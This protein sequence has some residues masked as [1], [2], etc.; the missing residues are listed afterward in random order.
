MSGKEDNKEQETMDKTQVDEEDEEIKKMR[1]DFEMIQKYVAQLEKRKLSS[2]GKVSDCIDEIMNSLKIQVGGDRN[3]KGGEQVERETDN[4]EKN[5]T[6]KSDEMSEE[7]TNSTQERIKKKKKLKKKPVVSTN[8]PTTLEMLFSKLDNRKVP[9]LEAYIEDNGLDLE[10]YLERFEDYF[11]E[12]YKGSSYLWLGELEGKLKGR[13]LEGYKSVKLSDDSFPAV[14]KKLIKWYRDE[15]ESRKKISRKNFEK[16]KMKSNESTLM[17]SNRLL[18][19]FKI[20]YPKKIYNTSELLRTKF[21]NTVSKKMK[22]IIDNQVLCHKINDIKITYE[23]LQKCA[24]IYDVENESRLEVSDDDEIV[25]INFSSNFKNPMNNKIKSNW[26]KENVTYQQKW[27]NNENNNNSP[28]FENL[29][30]NGKFQNNFGQTCNY[31]GRYGHKFV[32]CR[33]RLKS[34]FICGG[35]DHFV[36]DCRERREN[37]HQRRS[38]VSPNR[39]FNRNHQRNFSQQRYHPQ[40]QQSLGSRLNFNTPPEPRDGWR[41]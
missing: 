10:E 11:K 3:V 16:A 21:T 13:T 39:R 22:N 27:K 37:T 35:N 17:Y 12:N 38:S 1:S 28:R 9:E 2:S 32:D 18:Q 24:S 6:E 29:R 23:K 15:K 34:C 41:L 7:D 30:F 19:L 14:K 20:A 8:E 4:E 25:E 40:N 36:K 31:C 5:E 33:K 26:P